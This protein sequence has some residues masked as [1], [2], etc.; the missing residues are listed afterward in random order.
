MP[1]V[2][3]ILLIGRSKHT[4][5]Q[6]VVQLAPVLLG[7]H[8]AGGFLAAAVAKFWATI[9]L[10]KNSPFSIRLFDDRSQDVMQVRWLQPQFP[11][12]HVLVGSGYR[13]ARDRRLGRRARLQRR[14]RRDL[15]DYQGSHRFLSGSRQAIRGYVDKW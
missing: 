2:N 6:G 13:G 15:M 5:R 3:R 12:S 4:V 14:Q 7:G 1:A 11:H 9:E 8:V 10:F